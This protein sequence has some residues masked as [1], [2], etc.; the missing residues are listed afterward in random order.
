MKEPYKPTVGKR[1]LGIGGYPAENDVEGIYPTTRQH[2]PLYLCHVSSARLLA[3]LA[4]ETWCKT[5]SMGKGHGLDLLVPVGSGKLFSLHSGQKPVVDRACDEQHEILQETIWLSPALKFMQTLFGFG[6]KHRIPWNS[7]FTNLG[8]LPQSL[9]LS[10][11]MFFA[12]QLSH[13]FWASAF[14][15]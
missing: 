15:L 8:G 13:S 9:H 10:I 6:P 14:Y 11:S 5:D 4:R 3:I 12:Y 1:G 7:E 2:V